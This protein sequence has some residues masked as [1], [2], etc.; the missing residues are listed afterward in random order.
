LY[1]LGVAGKIL[2]L[3][4][5]RLALRR[6]EPGSAPVEHELNMG[7]RAPSEA[8]PYTRT[9][10][11]PQW[12]IENALRELLDAQGVKT[13]YSTRLESLVLGRDSVRVTTSSGNHVTTE[14]V[15]Y[16]V[17]CDGASSTVRR[18]IGVNFT[19]TTDDSAHL[20]TADLRI[21]GLDR[22]F[23]HI[24]PRAG[25]GLLALCPLPA[26][27]A[28]QL[29]ADVPRSAREYTRETVAELI[30]TGTGRDD[31]T[32]R[33][34]G[35]HSIWRSNVRLAEHFRAG[36]V[37]LAGDAAHIHPP[38]GGLGMN[39]GMQDAANLGWKLAH[40]LAGAPV[41]LLD[42]YELE[43]RPVA[44]HALGLSGQIISDGFAQVLSVEGQ[45]RD[46]LQLDI[47]YRAKTVGG[48]GQFS[49]PEGVVLT[50]DRAPD[51]VGRLA[52][53]LSTRLFDLFRGTHL[54]ILAFGPE[55][56]RIAAHTVKHH[57]RHV[58]AYRIGTAAPD[59][60]YGTTPLEGASG[61][62]AATYGVTEDCI[63]VVRPDGYVG[64]RSSHPNAHA[65]S[66]YLVS[67]LPPSR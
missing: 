33:A 36:R 24:W 38:S 30:R 31:I 56:D 13:E 12:R 53:R 10:I 41:G 59:D 48:A 6:Y 14:Q 44:A 8:T 11:I 60:G 61:I 54:T 58:M 16:V 52:G 46:T 67:V 19:G 50:G 42:T 27:E 35:W 55:S 39:T 4:R 25:G 1:D 45:N 51:G 64:Y 20:L 28:Y 26:C 57:Q 34:L 62:I 3:G 49:N 65:L 15:A 7:A 21:E 2:T 18:E 23:W 63:I 5:S 40:V 47:T 17:G 29:Q 32:V 22:D 37:F 9:M 43:R 66:E